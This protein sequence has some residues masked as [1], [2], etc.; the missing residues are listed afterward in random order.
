M[1]SN[2]WPVTRSSIFGSSVESEDLA[3][4]RMEGR[5]GNRKGPIMATPATRNVAL[6][7]IKLALLRP[8]RSWAAVRER[9]RRLNSRP[10]AAVIIDG[11]RVD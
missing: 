9:K 3:R 8:G 2:G 11:R 10:L 1:E 5:L 4:A 6:A 7:I